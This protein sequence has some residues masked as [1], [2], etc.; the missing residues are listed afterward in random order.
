MLEAVA[1]WYGCPYGLKN[2]IKGGGCENYLLIDPF[3]SSA[4]GIERGTTGLRTLC[5][6]LGDLDH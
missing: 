3:L 1:R 2:Y 4:K 5:S 6:L